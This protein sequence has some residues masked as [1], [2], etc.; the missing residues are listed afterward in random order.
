VPGLCSPNG[1][2][3]PAQQAN[4]EDEKDG[5]DHFVVETRFCHAPFLATVEQQR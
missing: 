1:E 4:A 3:D 2:R 5:L